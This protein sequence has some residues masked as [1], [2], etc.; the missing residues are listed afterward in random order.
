MQILSTFVLTLALLQGSLG[1]FIHLQQIN[2]CSSSN[3]VKVICDNIPEGSCCKTSSRGPK[4]AAYLGTTINGDI[5][6]NWCSS[7]PTST[8]LSNYCDSAENIGTGDDYQRGVCVTGRRCSG[9]ASWYNIP[10]TCN[11]WCQRMEEVAANT[12]TA[13]TADGRTVRKCTAEVFGDEIAHPKEGGILVIEAARVEALQEQLADVG[14]N[15]EA[16]VNRFRELGATYYARASEFS[17]TLNDDG[18]TN[19]DATEESDSRR[20]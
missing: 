12:A 16:R 2:N 19:L 8:V 1:V 14:E 10:D 17:S 15:N 20:N 3:P 5:L 18:T 13:T 6:I 7:H 11:V 4:Y 9:G